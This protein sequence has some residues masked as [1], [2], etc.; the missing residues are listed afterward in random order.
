MTKDFRDRGLIINERLEEYDGTTAVVKTEHVSAEEAE[1]MRWKVERWMKVRHIP[2]A[3]RHNPMY[4]LKNVPKMFEHTFRG[5]SL[6]T[7]L[8]LEDERIA[9]ERYRE[10]RRAERGYI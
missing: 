10:I 7:F 3:F 1:Y 9:F 8:G 4:V 2:A 6:K 5:S